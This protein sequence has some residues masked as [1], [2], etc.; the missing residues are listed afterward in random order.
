MSATVQRFV[1]RLAVLV[2]FLGVMS[3]SSGVAFAQVE[4]TAEGTVRHGGEASL[5]VPDLSSVPRP[6]GSSG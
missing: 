6:P 3:L 4:G 2:M 5:V 1:G